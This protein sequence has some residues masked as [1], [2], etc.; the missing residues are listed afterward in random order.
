MGRVPI[1]FELVA[2]QDLRGHGDL[3]LQLGTYRHTFDSCY[4]AEGCNTDVPAEEIVAEAV[5]SLLDQWVARLERLSPED[6]AFLPFDLSDQCSAW[7]LVD[8]TG[9][10]PVVVEAGWSLIEGWSF[11]PRD[12]MASRM[13][14]DFRP[15][16]GAKVECHLPDLIATLRE[17][18]EALAPRH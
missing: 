6:A 9:A 2:G 1:A 14:D 18:R 8:N 10:G 7:L 17:L 4:L 5:G 3:L 11:D 15:I 13:P 12:V 16:D